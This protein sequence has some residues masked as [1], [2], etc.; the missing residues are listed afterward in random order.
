[1]PKKLSPR[2]RELLAELHEVSKESSGPLLSSFV[3]RM[4]KLFGS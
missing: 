4:K 3:D 1:V 2:E